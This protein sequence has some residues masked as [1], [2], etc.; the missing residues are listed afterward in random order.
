MHGD[1]YAESCL[2]NRFAHDIGC[3]FVPVYPAVEIISG[4]VIIKSH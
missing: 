4:G 1:L 2:L 3:S